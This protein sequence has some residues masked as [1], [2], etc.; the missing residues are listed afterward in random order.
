MELE[1]AVSEVPEVAEAAVVSRSDPEKG[2]VPDVYVTLRDG[3]DSE[4]IRE[5]IIEAVERDIGKFAR[6][7]H[8][9]IV[10]DLPKTRSG[11]IMRRLLEN[12][13]NDDELGDTTTLRDP[14]VPERIRDQV[15]D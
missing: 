15:Q 14:S 5:K 6:P 13:S 7:E 12:I 8:V 2:E 9:V 10:D 3:V 1:S 11:K 4:G